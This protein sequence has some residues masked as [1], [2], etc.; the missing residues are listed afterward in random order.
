ME[1]SGIAQDE[2]GARQELAAVYRLVEIHGWGESIYNHISLRVPNEP[3]SFLIK[4]HDRLYS[5]VTASNLVKV[6]IEGD[7]DEKSGVNRPGYVLHGGVLQ[8]RPDVNC[9]LHVHTAEGIAIS[10][11]VEPLRMLSQYAVRFYGR[12]GYH[13]YEGITDGLDERARIEQ[14]L[15]QNIALFMRNHGVLTVA[16]SARAAFIRIKDLLEACRIELMLLASGRELVEVP[17]EVC[18]R[19]VR[20][21][22]AHDDG[23]GGADWPA[24]LRMLDSMDPSWRS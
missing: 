10:A 8:C 15:G 13:P 6:S 24:Y 11:C 23:R 22:A 9:A 14:H 21:F 20:Q 1:H 5:E 12:V 3:G 7:L 19:T 16:S 17:A 4:A 18:E 2:W